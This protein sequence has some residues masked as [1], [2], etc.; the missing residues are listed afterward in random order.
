MSMYVTLQFVTQYSWN[1]V[2]DILLELDESM[3]EYLSDMGKIK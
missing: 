2:C 3:T 1:L